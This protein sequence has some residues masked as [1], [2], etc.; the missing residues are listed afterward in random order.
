MMTKREELALWDP[1]K[2]QEERWTPALLAG[3]MICYSLTGLMGLVMLL[4]PGPTTPSPATLTTPVHSATPGLSENWR[5]T[6]TLTAA[7][8]IVEARPRPAPTEDGLR[9][10][11]W[12]AVR[13]YKSIENMTAT[14][15]TLSEVDNTLE[16]LRRHGEAHPDR[17]L[18]RRLYLKGL[19]VAAYYALDSGD[20]DRVRDLRSQFD[21]YASRFPGDAEVAEELELFDAQG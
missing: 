4:G 9:P 13:T 10:V 8:V 3:A 6:L 21:A 20:A 12:E 17:P 16:R 19:R 1:D 5:S 2:A 14:S 11:D 7:A 15:P 18:V